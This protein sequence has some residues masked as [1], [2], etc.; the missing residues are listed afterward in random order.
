M[1]GFARFL[2]NAISSDPER[3]I[4]ALNQ[5]A[6]RLI[7]DFRLTWPNFDWWKDAEFNAYLDRFGERE[8]FNTHRR[9]TLAQ[10]LKLAPADGDTAECGVFEGSSSWLIAQLGRRHHLF[11]SFEGLS[12]P[13]EKD[14]HYWTVAALAAGQDIVRSNLSMFEERLVFHKGWIP[15]RFAE[16]SDKTFAFV[17]I[18]VDLYQPTL[19]SAAF[20][21]PRMV[22]GGIILCDDYGSPF[23]PG[24]TQAI[25]EFMTDKPE[26]VIILDAGGCFLIKR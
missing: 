7:P 10:L 24:A 16:V 21:Y 14:G 15:E 9:W 26:P 23:C 3:R 22:E 13:T 19:D 1:I 20:F 11:D 18:D 25:D 17:H 5:L 12:L 8:G 6:R 4:R 2:R